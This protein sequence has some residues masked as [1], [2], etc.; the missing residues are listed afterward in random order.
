ML[1]Y[2]DT[3]YVGCN[4]IEAATMLTRGIRL[5]IK[6]IKMRGATGNSMKMAR[7]ARPD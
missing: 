6:G 1:G 2:L 3:W 7:S 4:W 5:H